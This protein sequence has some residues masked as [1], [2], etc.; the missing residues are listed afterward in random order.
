MNSIFISTY[1]FCLFSSILSIF[2]VALALGAPW[3][4]MAMGGKS[5]G[6][7]SLKMRLAALFQLILIILSLLI[8][9]VRAKLLYTEYFE[10]SHSVIWF[11]VGIF[12]ISLVLNIATSSK[13][14]RLFGA[15]IAAILAISSFYVALS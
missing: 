6:R 14:E 7:F 5:P 13:K 3:G 15:P 8:V 9:L 11:V 12:S 10:L 2:Q 1:V 4:E